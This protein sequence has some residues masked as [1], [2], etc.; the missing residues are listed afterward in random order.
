MGRRA[1]QKR[2]T[3]VE[4]LDE[5]TN[6]NPENYLYFVGIDPS[7]SSTGFVILDSDSNEPL[8]AQKIKAGR[9]NDPFHK[10]L[11]LLIDKIDE[12][13]VHYK[14][15]NVHVVM[16]GAAFA[17]EFGAFKLGKLSGVLEYYL[18]SN[19]VD[20]NLVAPTYVKRVAAG[21]GAATKEG[22]IKGVR[23]RWGYVNSSNDINDA[24]T[25]AQIARG[26]K[27]LPPPPKTKPKKKG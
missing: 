14:H 4:Y 6:I 16:E 22:V 19:G 26:A 13:M 23:E 7:Y 2:S 1:G 5:T 3:T 12:H 15:G 8:V 27:P 9:P 21:S 25:M 10:R 24:Y 11:K 17:S 18:G 20:Y